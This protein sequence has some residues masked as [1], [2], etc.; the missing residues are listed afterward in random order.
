MP[1][2]SESNS[3]PTARGEKR[4]HLRGWV[5]NLVLIALAFGAVQWWNTRPLAS[6]PAP[7]LAGATLAGS[8]F[9]L[10]AVRAEP[11]L[12]HFWATWCPV[13]RMMEATIDGIAKDHRAITVA[14]QS[15]PPKEIARFMRKAGVDFPVIADP[16]GRIASQWGV[17]GVPATFVVDAAGQIRDATV[18]F[19]TGPGLRARLWLATHGEAGR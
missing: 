12:V 1:H 11:I 2:D 6:G 7:P 17:S 9:D 5:L 10:S 8:T 15:G 3:A 4:R 18:G 13:C 14:L 19:S 16:D